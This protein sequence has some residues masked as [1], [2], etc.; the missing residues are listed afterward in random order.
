M[1]P[2]S[3]PCCSAIRR[4]RG[5]AFTAPAGGA[6]AAGG[7]GM[8]PV[9]AALAGGM[10]GA[11]AAASPTSPGATISAIVRPTGTTSP[12]FAVTSR[13][14]PEAGASISTVTLSV[15]I[16]TMGSP[17][18]TVSPGRLSQ[19]TTLPVSCASSRAGM[20]TLAGIA[21]GSAGE[22]VARDGE[23]PL[24]RVGVDVQ[25]G[26][27]A[28]R[29]RPERPHAHA[30]REHALARGGC[31][32]RAGQL[33]EDDVRVDR[34]RIETHARQAGQAL[35]QTPR[36]RVVLGQTLHVVAQRPDAAGGDDPGLTHGPAHLLLAPPR[37]VDASPRARQR[38]RSAGLE[39]DRVRGVVGDHL[40][41]GPRVHAQ[42]DLVAHRARGQE[43]RGFLAE[44]LGDH[45]A[46]HVDGR[47]LEL[48][49]VAHL[50]VAHEAA[51]LPRGARDGIAEEVDV[52]LHQAFR[53]S[54]FAA[55]ATDFSVGTVRSSSTGENGTGTSMA[56]I[57]LTGAS[58]W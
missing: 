43:H 29:A 45:L 27:G 15:S 19:W 37:L 26:D 20:R 49:L 31:G 35:G 55:S 10:T 22:D 11:A 25:V 12:S 39:V 24:D 40:F 21:S 52:D 23:R 4:A 54:A 2:R 50:G 57:R 1:R 9:A 53:Q 16:S 34:P 56:P 58:S 36:V 28:N 41:A 5:D 38:R 30:P 8:A 42:R 44:Q 13:S 48:L 7:A 18:R 6:P 3:T 46:E 47:I 14:T 33:E 17:L 51:H 32:Q